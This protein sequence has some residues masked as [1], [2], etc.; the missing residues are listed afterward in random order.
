MNH[1]EIRDDNQHGSDVSFV[2]AFLE[3]VFVVSS[4]FGL[5]VSQTMGFA[6]VAGGGSKQGKGWNG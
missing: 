2:F 1:R 5:P 3:K 4:L 6:T